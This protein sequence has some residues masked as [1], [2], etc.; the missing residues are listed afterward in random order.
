[1]RRRT[2]EQRVQARLD[3]AQLQ[4]DRCHMVLQQH[5]HEEADRGAFWCLLAAEPP[6]VVE[7]ADP[8]T[9]RS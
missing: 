1:M 9:G 7:I 5:L 2:P 4:A 6:A 8:W 3:R